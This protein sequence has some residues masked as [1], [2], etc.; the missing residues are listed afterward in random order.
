MPISSSFHAFLGAAVLGVLSAAGL[1]LVEHY[2][3]EKCRHAMARDLAR[4][5]H[6]L[7]QVKKELDQLLTK[8]KEKPHKPRKTRQVSK[9]NSILSTTTDDYLSGSNVDSS[10]LE[11]YDLSDNEDVPNTS[12]TILEI[13]ISEIDR[14]LDGGTLSELEKTLEKLEDL[15]VEYPENPEL[16]WRIGKAHQKISDKSDDTDFI[17]EHVTKGIQAC[18]TALDLK[19]DSAEIHKWYAILI[20]SR[21]DFVSLQEKIS[22]GHLFKKHVDEAIAL[23]PQDPALHHM[24]G[25]FDY[26]VAGLKWY[27][28]KV[29]AALF[30]EPPNATYAE[31]LSH[32]M[33]AEKLAHFEWKENKLMIA[34]CKITSGDYQEAVEW[35]ERANG[36][37][38]GDGL[39]DKVD[40]EVKVLLEK[41]NS[42]R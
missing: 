35:L 2:R 9:A 1:Y 17:R 34:K 31:A 42:Y 21:S 18:A 40:S 39:D 22:D 29:A 10:D 23:N 11:F 20:G 16:L 36:C 7:S 32:F 26:E 37:K 27:E 38:Q 28:R 19:S 5:D 6:E 33:K 14:K 30:A 15:C 24:L 8:K 25:R 3:H 13:V 41:Y 12:S 4:L